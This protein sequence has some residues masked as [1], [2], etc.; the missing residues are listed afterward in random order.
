MLNQFERIKFPNQKFM[1][2]GNFEN[3]TVVIS[4]IHSDTYIGVKAI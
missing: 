1:K 3:A 2:D 4:G